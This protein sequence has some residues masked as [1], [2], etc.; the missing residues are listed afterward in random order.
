MANHILFRLLKIFSWMS[1]GECICSPNSFGNTLNISIWN[2]PLQNITEFTTTFL[3]ARC[4]H[5]NLYCSGMMRMC[6]PLPAEHA[7]AHTHTY[8]HTWSCTHR[9]EA[10]LKKQEEFQQSCLTFHENFVRYAWWVLSER[11]KKLREADRKNVFLCFSTA[12]GEEIRR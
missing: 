12:I 10:V 5:P 9:I 6:M 2:L 8:E 1:F 7:S 3:S 4:L 11:P